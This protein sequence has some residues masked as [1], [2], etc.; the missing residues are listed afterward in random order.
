MNLIKLLNKE[1]LY[2]IGWRRN[3]NLKLSMECY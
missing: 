2:W 1:L 3:N